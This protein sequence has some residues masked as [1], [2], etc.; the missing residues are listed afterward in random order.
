MKKDWVLCVVKLN[1]EFMTE[2][3]IWLDRQGENINNTKYLIV[4][5]YDHPHSDKENG[6]PH[7]HWH[8]NTKYQGDF[9]KLYLFECFK[10]GRISKPKRNHNEWFEFKQLYKIS[11]FESRKTPTKFIEK[12]KLKHKC[13]HKGKCTHRGFDLSNELP[14]IDGVITC[15]LHGLRFNA[16]TK[17]M[18][19][20]NSN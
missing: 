10:G 15:P 13:I 1:D 16:K 4:P 20:E 14:D 3:E 2:E 17:E 5:L 11:E 12:S 6:Q 18:I 7:I 8:Q 9:D 19:Y